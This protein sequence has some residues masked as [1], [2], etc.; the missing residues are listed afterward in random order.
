LS[1]YSCGGSGVNYKPCGLNLDFLDDGSMSMYEKMCYMVNLFQDA[2]NGLDGLDEALNL[3]EDKTNLTNVRRLDESGNFTGTW[4]GQTK[5]EFKDSLQLLIDSLQNQID[6]LV[7]VDESLALEDERIEQKFD[8]EI[9]QVENQFSIVDG[10]L[11]LKENSIDIT[12]IRKL[13]TT[14]N[15]T[16]TWENVAFTEFES[17][18]TNASTLYQNVIELIQSN[19]NIGITVRDGGFLASLVAPS[20]E[21]FGL[22]TDLPTLEI[23]YGLVIYPC[24][25]SI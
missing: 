8:S 20:V 10:Q 19:P 9:L 25:C 12:N 24:V 16:G 14:G 5:E 3:K 11:D 23:D 4:F 1:Y 18:V 17:E 7:L 13:S 21:D 6:A 22:V 15:F 2:L